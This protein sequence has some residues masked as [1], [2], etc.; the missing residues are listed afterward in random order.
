[1]QVGVDLHMPVL[2]VRDDHSG[3]GSGVDQGSNP[4]DEV[5]HHQDPLLD[6]SFETSV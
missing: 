2:P 1:M 4:C 5:V 3:A 6:F